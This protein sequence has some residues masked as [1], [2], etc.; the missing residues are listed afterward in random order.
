MRRP[1]PP[2]AASL[3]SALLLLGTKG[4]WADP[5]PSAAHSSLKS[6]GPT[7]PAKVD[8]GSYTDKD[9]T[10]TYH[11]TEGGKMVDWP[12]MSGYVRYNANCIVCH[13]PDGAGSTYAPSLVEALKRDDYATFVG[14]VA[15]GKKD[16]N[17]AQ[18]LV[19]PAFGDNRN[20]MCYIDDIYVYLRA[21]ADGVIGRGR[22]AE[23]EPK[24]ESFRKREDACM[25]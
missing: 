25:G 12:A 23:H 20:V 4:A 18:Q 11:V 19:M 10:P 24:S 17:S 9:G 15:G 22:P 2:V 7:Q 5:P 3:A 1:A 13:G 6:E 14:I 21:R 16:V 8:D